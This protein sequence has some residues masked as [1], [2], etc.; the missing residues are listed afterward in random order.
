MCICVLACLYLYE[1]SREKEKMNACV[2]DWTCKI[3]GLCECVM[4]LL[5]H[6]EPGG[7]WTTVNNISVPSLWPQRLC[8]CVWGFLW[9]TGV[10]S[11]PEGGWISLSEAALLLLIPSLFLCC[12]APSVLLFLS[13]FLSSDLTPHLRSFLFLSFQSHISSALFYYHI[14]V[15]A[16]LIFLWWTL[17]LYYIYVSYKVRQS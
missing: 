1:R 15:F 5:D 11:G 16:V 6:F 12:S 7:R 14:L 4:R 17:I 10:A 2:C 3:G 8:V 9:R 13:P